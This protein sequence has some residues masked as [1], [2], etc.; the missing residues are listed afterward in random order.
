MQQLRKAPELVR[1]EIWTHVLAYRLNRTLIVQAAAI[2]EL[3]PRVGSLPAGRG[4][5]GYCQ[6]RTAHAIAPQYD[7]RHRNSSRRRS[8]GPIRASTDETKAKLL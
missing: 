2:H 7:G 4:N 6:S 3:M 8:T 1:K 5:I